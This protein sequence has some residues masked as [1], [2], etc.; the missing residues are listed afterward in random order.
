MYNKFGRFVNMLSD[1]SGNF[2][3]HIIGNFQNNLSINPATI[4]IRHDKKLYGFIIS[5]QGRYF[6][7][8]KDK[9][10]L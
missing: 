2:S 8:Q 10:S 3:H 5:T 9:V 1:I 6:E 4:V 7:F